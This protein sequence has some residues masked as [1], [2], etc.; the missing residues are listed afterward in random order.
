MGVQTWVKV[1]STTVSSTEYTINEIPEEASFQ[2]RISAVNDFGQSAYLEIPGTF[3]LGKKE[4]SVAC[5]GKI[6]LY[7]PYKKTSAF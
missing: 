3:Y 4:V 7:V 5:C 2:F 1:T 6:I